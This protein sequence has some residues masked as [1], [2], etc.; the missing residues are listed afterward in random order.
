[1]RL[2][3]HD[4]VVVDVLKEAVPA[5]AAAMNVQEYPLTVP[6]TWSTKTASNWAGCK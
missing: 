5:W 6:I 2:T 1:M 3:V 4:E